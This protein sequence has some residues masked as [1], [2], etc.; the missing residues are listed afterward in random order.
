[1]IAGVASTLE[2][3]Q[4]TR[5]SEKL[6]F[7]VASKVMSSGADRWIR[8]AMLGATRPTYTRT[9]RAIP[10]RLELPILLNARRLTGTGVEVGVD[11]GVFSEYLLENWRGRKLVS[12]DPWLEMAPEEYQDTCNTSQAS[13][14]EKYEATA[15]RLARFGDRSEILREMSVDAAKRFATRS[16]DFVYLD[17]R[18]S[19][20][21]VAE[22]LQAW[23]PLMRAGGLMAGHDYNDGVFAEGVHCVRSAVDEFFGARG[24]PVRHTY[25]D[26][27]TTSWIA[28]IPRS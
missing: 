20:E 24:I 16:L 11:E 15:S 8:A 17:A 6:V 5:P 2:H 27:P 19:Y 7:F 13:M 23:F 1:M 3:V 25:T 9:L 26:V 12:V 10:S 4:P 18:H 28:Q 14:E 21:G 22:D